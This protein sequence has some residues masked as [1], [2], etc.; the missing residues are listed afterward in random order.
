LTHQIKRQVLPVR[1]DSVNVQTDFQQIQ[2]FCKFAEKWKTD[3]ALPELRHLV[4]T[5][6][7][8]IFRQIRERYNLEDGEQILRP[9][10]FWQI[11][12]DCDDQLIFWLSLFRFCGVPK[13]K[14][15]VIEARQPGDDHYEHIFAGLY[16]AGEIIFLDCLPDSEFNKI[17][18]SENDVRVSLMSDYV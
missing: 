2:E 4:D 11:G 16:N 3:F 13:S 12:S 17:P 1:R 18:Y 7:K 15:L 9:K 6:L 5:E 10:Y 14:I 8:L